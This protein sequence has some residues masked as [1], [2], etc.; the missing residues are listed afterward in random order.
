MRTADVPAIWYFGLAR[1]EVVD[2][3]MVHSVIDGGGSPADKSNT[4]DIDLLQ[5]DG[6]GS[7][8]GKV[9]VDGM[10]SLQGVASDKSPERVGVDVISSLNSSSGRMRSAECGDV[11]IASAM[12]SQFGKVGGVADGRSEWAS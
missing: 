1:K 9:V 12:I 5:V 4:D 3:R 10:D 7:P 6:C 8:A 11:V 2:V